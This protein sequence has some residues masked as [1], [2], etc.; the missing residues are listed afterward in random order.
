[1]TGPTQ[2]DLLLDALVDH[3]RNQLTG[4]A[5]LAFV[6][7]EIDTALRTTG[8]LTLNEVV[9]PEQIT[10]TA[11][12]YASQWTIEGSIPELVGEIAARLYEKTTHDAVPLRN[13]FDQDQIQEFTGSLIALPAFRRLIY[14]SPLTRE[15]AVELICQAAGSTVLASRIKAEQV[16]G[17]GSVLSAAELLMN[18]FAPDTRVQAEIRIRELA[19]LVVTYF[20]NRG[21]R[22]VDDTSLADAAVDL[23][24]EHADTPMSEIGQMVTPDDVEDFLVLAFEFFFRF[25][26]TEY[27]RSVVSEG[28][29]YFFEKYGTWTLADLLEDIG[30][31]PNDMAEEARRYAPPIIDLLVRN[32]QFDAIVRRLHAGFFESDRVQQILA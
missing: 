12:K 9:T 19:E 2:A 23:W 16:P 1:M 21:G 27:F 3:W 14:E 10:A 6:D 25:R 22:P 20:Q 8:Q 24:A 32:G 26:Q 5:L 29:Q 18:R 4:D 7:R 17:L 31:G 13:V 11:L 15:W 30:V 28:V